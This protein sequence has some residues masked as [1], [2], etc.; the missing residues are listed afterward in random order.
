MSSSESKDSSKEVINTTQLVTELNV[1]N[2]TQLVTG[3]TDKDFITFC[4]SPSYADFSNGSWEVAV[5]EIGFELDSTSPSQDH[6][7]SV[8]CNHCEAKYYNENDIDRMEE[9]SLRFFRLK[10]SAGTIGVD[11]CNAVV[12]YPITNTTRYNRLS[13]RKVGHGKEELFRNRHC[14]ITTRML[15]RRVK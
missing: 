7:I 10:G 4:V 6:M 12:F 2:K 3:R 15:F 14:T 1:I 8:H 9:L 11:P 13:F 5:G